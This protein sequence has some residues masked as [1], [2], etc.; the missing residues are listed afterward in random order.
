[1]KE[2]ISDTVVS[3]KNE[4]EQI[5][6]PR[7]ARER[8]LAGIAQAKRENRRRSAV[9]LL[10]RTAAAGA[11]AAACMV[12]L[13]NV[14]PSVANAMER[15]PVIGAIARVVTLDTYKDQT[16]HFEADIQIP[17]VEGQEG[18][19]TPQVNIS[20]EEYAQSLIRMYEQDLAASQGEGNYSLTS[21]YE[22]V[23]DNDK[24]L[25]LRINTT[26]VMASGT[27]FVKIFTVDK[28]TGKVITLADLLGNDPARLEAVSENIKSQ[29]AAQMAA[30]ESVMSFYQ[31]DTPE[32]DF[33]GLSG[34]E[35]F[36][37]DSQGQ[38]VITF[39][40]YEVAPG[41]MGAVEF[42]IPKEV[43]GKL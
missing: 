14:S 35:S 29:M 15:I 37:L 23:T 12:L 2:K 4:Y 22:V 41:Y 1:M 7:E 16:N 40:E 13:V 20:I 19:E 30:D 25:S 31:S 26:L 24:Y 6:V 39:D 21:S 32:M 9:R 8:M 10:G 3:L 11:A 38:L 28:S 5:P 42:T 27:E 36:Y 43:T 33:K 34:D 18:T 17:K